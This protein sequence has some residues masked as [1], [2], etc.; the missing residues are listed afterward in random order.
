MNFDITAFA[1]F[2][3][4]TLVTRM[5]AI[6]SRIQPVFYH[7]GDMI[8]H[9]I[10]KELGVEQVPVHVAKHLR[11][12]TNPPESTWVGIGGNQR[13]YK[14]FPHFQI[15]INSEYVFIMLALID[16]PDYEKEIAQAWQKKVDQWQHLPAD[17]AVIADHTQLAYQPIA[18]VDWTNVF[19]R[20]EH[21]KKAE[22][23][24]G[25]IAQKGDTV[26]SDER[27]LEQWLVETVNQLLPWYQEACAFH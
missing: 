16:N 5:E 18:V 15:G 22:F 6:Q 23:M 3:Q 20:M 17:Y 25:R 21:V 27:Q 8:A 10:E 13:G 14:R 9:L 7:Y 19:E 11:R 1:V 24:V 4:D 12:T 2:E 26:L